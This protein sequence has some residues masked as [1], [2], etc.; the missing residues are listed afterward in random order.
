MR[1]EK[2]LCG[3]EE[4]TAIHDLRAGRG[5]GPRGPYAGRAIMGAREKGKRRNE[6]GMGIW[7][8]ERRQ[9]TTHNERRELL[10]IGGGEVGHGVEDLD[11]GVGVNVDGPVLWATARWRVW[12]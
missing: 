6:K 2:A 3:H 9:G 1:A 12:S 4:N 10:L 8:G 5:R 11:A 7:V